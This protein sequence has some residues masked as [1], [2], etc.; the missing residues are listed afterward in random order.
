MSPG[1]QRARAP[2]LLRNVLTGG[3]L[4]SFAVGV[5]AYSLSA[6]AQDD[7]SD[8]DEEAKALSASSNSGS[9]STIAASSSANIVA[10]AVIPAPPVSPSASVVSA[11]TKLE[12]TSSKGGIMSSVSWLWSG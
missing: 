3:I 10:P 8:V 5:W 7:F 4:T 9:S 6:V 2:F 12:E 11:Q 1:L